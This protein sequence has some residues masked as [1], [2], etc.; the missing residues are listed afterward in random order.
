MS[1]SATRF[2]ASALAPFLALATVFVLHGSARADEKTAKPEAKE[3]A[4]SEAKKVNVELDAD[5][6]QATIERRAGSTSVEGIPFVD[7]S[8][9]H[10]EH[11]CEAPCALALDPHFSYRV[12]G[13]GLVPTASF[14]LPHDRDRVR[15]DARMGS[16][17]TRLFGLVLGGSG[18]G[19]LAL[20]TAAMIA[21]PILESQDVGSRSF[22]S[23]LL[24]GGI[25]VAGA[26]LIAAG[27]G[28]YLFLSNGSVA[29]VDSGVGTALA[30][31][32][33]VF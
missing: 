12:S 18:L 22:R 33:I 29:H 25:G 1:S 11:A 26:G 3:D 31:G 21:S 7:A 30:R 5:H 16:S 13:D 17:T 4:K 15:I 23:G 10:W 28:L 14:S 24:A 6:A 20:G 19:A 27:A 8:L 2:R 32:G 9:A